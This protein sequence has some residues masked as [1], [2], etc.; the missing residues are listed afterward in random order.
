M[1]FVPD[2]EMY[3]RV[4]EGIKLWR[5]APLR[6]SQLGLYE[7]KQLP[8][9]AVAVWLTLTVCLVACPAGQEKDPGKADTCLP[10]PLGKYKVLTSPEACTDCDVDRT[11]LEE[12]SIAETNC[13]I[14]E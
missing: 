9:E 5:P 8:A 10:C 12:G 14:S 4:W 11:T 1:P 3:C 6:G 2:S 13:S 7:V